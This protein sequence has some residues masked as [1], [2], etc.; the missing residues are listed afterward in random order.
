MKTYL[1]QN[2]NLYQA[3]CLSFLST[4]DDDSID[5]IATDP[6]YFKVKGEAW[7]NQWKNKDEF[8]SWLNLV[9][10]EFHR[11]LKPTG[12]LYLFAGPHLATEVEGVVSRHFNMLNHVVWR[13]PSGRH[14]GCNKE[15]LRRYFPQTEHVLFAETRKPVPFAYQ[16]I[17]DHLEQARLAA[18]VSRKA[19]DEACGC[20]MSGHWFGRSQFAFPSEQHYNTINRLF[21]HKLMPYIELK[22]GFRHSRDQSNRAR[23]TF[24]VSKHVPYTNVWD[25]KPVQFYEGKHPCEKPLDLMTHII[26]AS[27]MPGDLVMD[28][29][30]GSGSTAISCLENDRRFIGCEMGDVEFDQA[31]KR[32]NG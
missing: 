32:I 7:D 9:L 10:A 13:K 5:L 16:A 4:I 29:F 21:G 26:T 2:L 15:S 17:L 19:V 11:V 31:V 20:Q 3:D 27:S 12:S 18:G 1:K 22:D 24:N 6:P 23:R 28:T 30:V 14:N 8:F 25:F